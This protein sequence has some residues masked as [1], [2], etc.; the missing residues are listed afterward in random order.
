M[1]T[2]CVASQ[3]SCHTADGAPPF[4][5]ETVAST[6][7]FTSNC[8]ILFWSSQEMMDD[9]MDEALGGDDEEEETD[10]LVGQ[11]S[12]CP[13]FYQLLVMWIMWLQL[14]RR[15][16]AVWIALPLQKGDEL[17]GQ[18]TACAALRN[19]W[20]PRWLSYA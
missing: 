1:S 14:S 15:D 13:A 9:T 8:C 6:L 7:A 5:V 2:A 18:M 20:R 17:V 10:A 12:T 4:L 16:C 3:G 11:A 19:T